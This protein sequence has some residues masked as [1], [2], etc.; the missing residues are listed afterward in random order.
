[1]FNQQHITDLATYDIKTRPLSHADLGQI[2]LY[3]NYFDQAVKQKNDNLTIGLVLYTK[4][5]DE[6][7]KYLLGDKAKQ[8]FTKTYQFHLP[9]EEELKIELKREIK[10][11]KNK[12]QKKNS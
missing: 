11:I 10:S 4:G 12:I 3:V 7:A 5:K 2:Q 6:M 9:T 1:M 8:I